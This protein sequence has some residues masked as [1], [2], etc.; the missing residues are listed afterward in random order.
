MTKDQII[1]IKCAYS[2]LVGVL[3][4]YNQSIINGHDWRSHLETIRDLEKQF[5]FLDEIP[6][7]LERK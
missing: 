1:A 3:Q 4:C 5:A 2:D 7:E 6:V